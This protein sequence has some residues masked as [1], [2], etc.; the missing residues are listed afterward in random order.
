MTQGRADGSEW[1][2]SYMVSYSLDAYHWTY[3]TDYYGNRRVRPE[4]FLSFFLSFFLFASNKENTTKSVNVY[5][6]YHVI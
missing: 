3:V 5:L 6:A 1:L 4:L 2:T